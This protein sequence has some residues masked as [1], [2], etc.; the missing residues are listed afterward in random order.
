MHEHNTIAAAASHLEA[1]AAELRD[2]Q[3]ALALPRQEY[4]IESAYQT[5]RL[6]LGDKVYIAIQPPSFNWHA[7]RKCSLTDWMAYDGKDH[8]HGSTLTDAV[9]KVLAA[10]EPEKHDTPANVTALLD[11]CLQPAGAA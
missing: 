9:N 3:T 2:M 7:G 10:H 5:L 11:A 4:D 6:R 8:H 1:L